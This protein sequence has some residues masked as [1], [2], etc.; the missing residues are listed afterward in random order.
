LVTGLIKWFFIG[1]DPFA[2]AV[3]NRYCMS[4]LQKNRRGAKYLQQ[5]FFGLRK[6]N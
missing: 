5:N 6:K 3:V 4:K 2:V 1:L